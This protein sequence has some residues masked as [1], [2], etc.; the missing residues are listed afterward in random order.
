MTDDKKI[1][2]K[3]SYLTS[4][5]LITF[6]NK[7]KILI[8]RTDNIKRFAD[9]HSIKMKIITRIGKAGAA[10]AVFERPTQ[11]KLKNIFENLKNV[12]NSLLGREMIKKKKYLILKLFDGAKNN[13][14]SRTSISEEVSKKLNCQC[15]RKYVRKILDKHRSSQLEKKLNKVI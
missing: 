11:T 6:L 1:V 14:V 2:E 10:P 8:N 12:S 15:N 5:E 9:Q 7:N 13:S 3:G 4:D